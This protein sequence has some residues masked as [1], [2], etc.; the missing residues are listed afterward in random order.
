[1]PPPFFFFSP[2]FH[3]LNLTLDFSL[4]LLPRLT[5]FW[6]GE[7]FSL[8]FYSCLLFLSFG[9]FQGVFFF[10]FGL[11][12]FL[13]TFFFSD[14]SDGSRAVKSVLERWRESLSSSSSLSQVIAGAFFSV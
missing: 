3:L 1:M 6:G 5:F 11:L 4:L 8:A 10:F 7:A 9:F 12:L 2:V 13:T 14:G